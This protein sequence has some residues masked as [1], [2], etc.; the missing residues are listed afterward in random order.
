MDKPAKYVFIG[1]REYVLK[2]MIRLRL[3]IQR[4][5]VMENSF[6]H[7]RLMQD[8]FIDYTVAGN[9][10]QL[11]EEL[12]DTCFDI[13]VSNGCK[14]ILPITLLKKAKMRDDILFINVHPSYLPDLKGMDPINGACLFN[15]AG[16]AT[17]HCMDDGIDTGTAIS[18]IKIPMSDDIDAGLLFQLS[19]KAEVDAFRKAF[20]AGFI[21]Q[22][23]GETIKEPI[24]Y[25]ISADEMIFN[26]SKGVDYLLRQA[27][28]FG[29]K[30]K[31]VCIRIDNKNYKYFDAETIKNQYVIDFFADIPELQIGIAFE[32]S[33]IFKLAGEIVRLNQL[34]IDNSACLEGHFI[35][36]YVQEQ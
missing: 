11:L 6:L 20:A 27:R 28:A 7:H 4:V 22:E 31:G 24:Y 26:G 2:E 10:K 16:G 17:C 14:Y 21:P 29:Y 12:K 1:N 32:R 35:Q 18:R 8:P 3:P 5:W 30:S 23:Q 9:K 13:L 36:E 25:T 33:I 34:T 19:F 15:R